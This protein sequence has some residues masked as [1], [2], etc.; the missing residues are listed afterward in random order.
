MNAATRRQNKVQHIRRLLSTARHK[1]TTSETSFAGVKR[2]VCIPCLFMSQLFF[3][4]TF[5]CSLK[6]ASTPTAQHFK[7]RNANIHKKTSSFHGS[8]G[9]QTNYLLFHVLLACRF[10]DCAIQAVE[11]R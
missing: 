8:N 4:N 7:S 1:S 9:T 6:T 10:A 5:C 11:I 2:L 3:S